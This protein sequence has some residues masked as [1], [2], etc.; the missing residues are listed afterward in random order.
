VQFASRQLP[1]VGDKKYGTLVADSKIALWSH[2]ISFYHPITGEF[3]KV[4][5]DTD[6]GAFSA[7]Q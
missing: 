3:I 7:F 4:S 2:K 5:A 6:E 1:L